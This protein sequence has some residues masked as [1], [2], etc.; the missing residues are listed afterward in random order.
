[1]ENTKL[2]LVIGLPGRTLVNEE[3]I[4][5]TNEVFT[6]K[7]V[8]YKENG[9]TLRENITVKMRGSIPAE[10]RVNISK[11][12]FLAFQSTIAPSWAK[13]ELWNKMTQ[14][15]KLEA[16]LTRHAEALG[17]WLIDYTILED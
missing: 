12:T 8:E 14:K 16:N 13:R 1:M 4:D 10:Q 9:K 15:Q 5:E 11:E 3:N 7:N 17:G 6:I 2:I